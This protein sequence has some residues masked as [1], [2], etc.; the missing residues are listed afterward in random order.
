M[1]VVDQHFAIVSLAREIPQRILRIEVSP[2]LA[3]SFLHAAATEERSAGSGGLTA[4]HGKLRIGGHETED[5]RR[6]P[7]L[8]ASGLLEHR[9]QA[10]SHF[11]ITGVYGHS[12]V[13]ADF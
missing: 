1:R 9:K 3:R 11:G 2:E 10:L 7:S 13:V 8:F 12:L 5:A 6:K 4:I